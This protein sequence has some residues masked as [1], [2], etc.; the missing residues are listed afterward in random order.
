[1]VADADRQRRGRIINVVKISV[2]DKVIPAKQ[3]AFAYLDPV[4]ADD[5]RTGRNAEIVTYRK[6]SK[7]TD[8]NT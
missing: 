3:D 7:I 4:M 2:H 1:M 6:L 5:G 8:T